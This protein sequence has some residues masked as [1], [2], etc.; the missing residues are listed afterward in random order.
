MLAGSS[1]PG[2]V[3][4]GGS[5]LLAASG[6][7]AADEAVG[8]PPVR[9]VGMPAPAAGWERALALKTDMN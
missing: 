6:E 9:T 7:E 3:S 2:S 5:L 4:A 8:A 1:A